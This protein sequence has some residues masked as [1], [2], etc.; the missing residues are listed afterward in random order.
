MTSLA[1]AGIYPEWVQVGNENNSGMLWPYGY[2][3]NGSSTPDV[4]NWVSFINKGYEAVKKVSPSSKVIIH[5]AEGHEN[6][7]FRT[8]FD[9][10]TTAE[11]NYDV[12]GMSY[13]PYWA[14]MD[15]KDSI[16]ELSYN[17]N[18]MASRYNKEVMVCEVGGLDSDETESYNLIK[19]VINAVMEVPNNKGLGVFYWEP[20]VTSSVLPDEYPLGACKE[21]S[22][23]TLKF[24]TALDAFKTINSSF[25]NTDTNYKIINKLSGK[26]LN[27]SG[28]SSDNGSTIEQY[29]YYTL[30]TV[31]I[32]KNGG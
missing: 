17:L 7:L 24:T 29:T 2:I 6:E 1:N 32:V 14:D 9:S 10:L 30:I 23:N 31:G 25:P 18:D 13:Y 5:L 16:D 27:V 21:V 19:A 4:T 20:A 12:I 15:Y 3:W 28:G 26:A 8:I 22:T 11:A